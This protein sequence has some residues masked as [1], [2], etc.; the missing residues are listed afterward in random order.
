[1]GDAKKRYLIILST[2]KTDKGAKATLAFAWGCSALSMGYEVMLMVTAEGTVWGVKGESDGI[3]FPGFEP[4]EDYIL[5]FKELGGTLCVCPPC[6]EH[7]C[8]IDRE[9]ALKGLRQGGELCGIA[10]AIEYS[11]HGAQVVNF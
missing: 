6:L 5:Q 11:A 9:T 3:H 8:S 10:R 1:M 2:G 7:Y 4:L